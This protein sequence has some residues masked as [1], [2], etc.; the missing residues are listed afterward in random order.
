MTRPNRLGSVRI[1][2]LVSALLFALVATSAAQDA[3]A[4]PPAETTPAPAPQA[5]P[6][7]PGQPRPYDRVI[8]KDA[9]SDAGIFTVHRIGERLYYEIPAN[10]LNKEFLWVSQ[11]ART[12]IGA[13]QGGQA[14]GSARMERLGRLYLE[15]LSG[16]G[17]DESLG[18]RARSA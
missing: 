15:A 2:L 12:T 11:I 5:A 13:G 7:G 9:K 1:L 17:S 6:A 10:Q 14:V 16:F 3:P 8:T 18:G 4:T